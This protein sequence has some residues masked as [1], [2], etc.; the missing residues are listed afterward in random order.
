MLRVGTA[1]WSLPRDAA[2][3]FPGG[4]AHLERY[5]RRLVCAE[6]N[7]TFYRPPRESTWRRW[8]ASVPETFRFAVKAPRAITHDAKLIGTGAAL[9]AFCQTAEMLG[10]RLGPLLFQLPPSLVF[11]DHSAEAFLRE[12][13]E[14]RA[15]PVVMEPRH[16][17]WFSQEVSALL[18]A[19]QVARV[20]ADP[21]R[22]PAAAEPGGWPGLVY[23]RLHGSPRIYYSRYPESYLAE[24][25]QR[26][27]AAQEAWCIF[28]NTASG[29]AIHNALELEQEAAGAR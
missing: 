3:A 10:G 13:R 8:A 18:E 26:L 20:A 9:A 4:G 15:G 24:L 14:V 21:A 28:D 6:I 27:R 2:E 11:D 7:S 17:S 5:A 12:L 25:G 16:A 1:G 19:F 22:V 29:A 23:Y